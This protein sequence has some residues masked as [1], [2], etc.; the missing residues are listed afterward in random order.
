MNS[1]QRFL[2]HSSFLFFCAKIQ[3]CKTVTE[4]RDSA[5]KIVWFTF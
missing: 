1:R 5:V 3:N 2:I 4:Q